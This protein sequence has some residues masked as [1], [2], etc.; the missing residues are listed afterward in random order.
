MSE[1]DESCSEFQRC[2]LQS[3]RT[4]GFVK[5]VF[6][7]P[8]SKSVETAS[9]IEIRPVVISEQKRL[10]RTQ[11]I[12]NQEHHDNFSPEQAVEQL[13]GLVPQNFRDAFFRS[14]T[15][16]CT[17]RTSRKG[18]GRIDRKPIKP[19]DGESPQ[20]VSLDHNRSK[21]YLISEGVPVPF[22]VETGIMTSAGKVRS[23]HFRKFRQINRYLEFI[24]DAI[25]KIPN[26]ETLHIV[27]FGCGKSYLTFAT[28][29]LLTSVLKRPCQLVGL[30][31]RKDVVATSQ[32]IAQELKL[33]NVA[34][35][36]TS[37]DR[38]DTDR[39]VHVAI[40]LHACDTASDDALAAAISW[41]AD[42]ILAA[43]CCHHELAFGLS[44][45]VVPLISQHG[46]LHERY[47]AMATDA[48]RAKLLEAC[49]YETQVIEFIEMEHTP[50]NLMI[51]AIRNHRRQSTT[52]T[53]ESVLAEWAS[54]GM[55]DLK[56]GRNLIDHSSGPV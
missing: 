27:D 25:K 56:L 39:P 47:A 44:R 20:N 19:T 35:Q 55:P 30:D 6:S 51:R 29:Y 41:K 50:R 49:G 38:Y 24:A 54:S 23:K 26:H 21:A 10:Q 3:I 13:A 43:P 8:V 40:S 42:A 14:Q 28:E 34:F 48:L 4:G 1:A 53:V 46:I 9:R 2:L 12:G 11:R 18:I 5:A 17:L 7:K 16:E 36:Q 37:I 22:L 32:K 31:L 33:Q 15:E 45:Q 52:G